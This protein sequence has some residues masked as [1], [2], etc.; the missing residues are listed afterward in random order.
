MGN[1]VER[2][3]PEIGTY[4]TVM[5]QGAEEAGVMYEKDRE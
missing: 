3:A 1:T 5:R 2:T 4:C